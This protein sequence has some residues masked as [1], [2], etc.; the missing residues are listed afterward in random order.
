MP[1]PKQGAGSKGG[2]P[3]ATADRDRG[4]GGSSQSEVRS[5]RDVIMSLNQAERTQSP[6][7]KR[8]SGDLG[9]ETTDSSLVANITVSDMKEL[10]KLQIQDFRNDLKDDIETVVAEMKAEFGRLQ[11]RV[12]ELEQHVADRD[13][14][15][16]GL[17]DQLNKKDEKVNLLHARLDDAEA[18][19]LQP[20]LIFAGTAVPARP[21]DGEEDLEK[22][23]ID[24]VKKHFPMT[25]PGKS[26]IA[27]IFRISNGKKI[28]CE[29]VKTGAGSIRDTVYQQRLS[30]NRRS[31][32]RLFV[33][34]FL[35]EDRQFI[36]QRLLEEKRKGKV[37]TVFTRNGSVFFK[38]IKGG[39]NIRVNDSEKLEAALRGL[40]APTQ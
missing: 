20:R 25:N 35:T 19:R 10:I 36:F 34:E 29:F 3:P 39:R 17:T 9:T 26:D 13:C 31:E 6:K 2:R 32:S 4:R 21:S 7:R 14:I 30:L 16:D 8:T 40:D 33:N 38:E 5:V 28:V 1:P 22:T 24:L 23:T 11:Q 27:K 15:I 18:E 12:S 37:Y